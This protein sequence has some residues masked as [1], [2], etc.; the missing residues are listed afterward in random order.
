VALSAGAATLPQP[1]E[2]GAPGAAVDATQAS[3]V[4]LLPGGDGIDGYSP[5]HAEFL[6]R[7]SMRSHRVD[8]LGGRL[9]LDRCLAAAVMVAALAA[10]VAAGVV[11]RKRYL[12]CCG[13]PDRSGELPQRV[14]VL[15]YSQLPRQADSRPEALSLA[16]AEE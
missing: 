6:I 5:G 13:P 12:R 3:A 2:A 8:P 15:K 9:L 11:V 4:Q 10:V 14:L 1:L 7:K 16:F